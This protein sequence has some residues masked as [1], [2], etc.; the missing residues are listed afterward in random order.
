MNI[1]HT[2]G[3]AIC[4]SGENADL[5][6][7]SWSRYSDSIEPDITGRRGSE[8]TTFLHRSEIVASGDASTASAR[9]RRQRAVVTRNFPEYPIAK[10]VLAAEVRRRKAS[11]QTWV[12]GGRT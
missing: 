7:G 9:I 6:T 4:R 11:R 5:G 8:P 1:L 2:L 12:L 3:N 10:G